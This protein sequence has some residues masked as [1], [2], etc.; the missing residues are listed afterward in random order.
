V[1]EPKIATGVVA[2]DDEHY[3]YLVGQYRYPIDVYSWEII[4]GGAELGESGLSAAQRELKEEA[5]ISAAS[6]EALGPS[7]Y[8]SNCFTSERAEVFLARNLT[9]GEACPDGDELLKTIRIP[10]AEAL[11]R[12]ARGEISDAVSI[13]A[14]QRAKHFLDAAARS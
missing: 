14:L 4:E 3:V 12:V 6:W 5:G 10:F 2:L 1:V 9:V 8:L 13:I 11:A 7:F